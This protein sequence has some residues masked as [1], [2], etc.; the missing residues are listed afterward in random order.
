M[1]RPAGIPGCP[2][3]LEYLTMVDQLLVHQQVEMVEV[4]LQ[5]EGANRYVIKNSMG[6][7][8]YF[9]AEESDVCTRQCCG[10]ARS[11]TIHITDNLGQEVI[12]LSREFKCCA[13]FNCS[14]CLCGDCCAHEVQIEAPPGN[15]IGFVK[16]ICNCIAPKYEIQDAGRQSIL[17]MEGPMCMCDGPC[18]PNDQEFKVTTPDGGNE[19][20]KISKQWSGF[21]KEMY[22]TADNFGVSFP[23]DLDVKIKAVMLGAVFL[24][25]FMFFENKQNNN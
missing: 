23:M 11:F 25:D 12:R 17:I 10:P 8:V 14:C 19:V 24:I 18:C 5:W 9:A 2:P 22:T 15:V 3:G 1:S 7:Q 4:F 13:Q 20:G 6:Q 21:L 16:Q